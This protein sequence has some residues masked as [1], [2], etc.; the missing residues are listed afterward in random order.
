MPPRTPKTTAA[1]WVPDYGGLSE[2][3][4]ASRGA[5]AMEAFIPDLRPVARLLA[6]EETRSAGPAP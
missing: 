6:S 3:R 2:L 1:P 4:R 5:E